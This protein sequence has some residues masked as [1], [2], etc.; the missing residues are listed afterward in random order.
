[1]NE[2]TYILVNLKTGKKIEHFEDEFFLLEDF[3]KRKISQGKDK[4]YS[5]EHWVGHSLF[6]IVELKDYFNEKK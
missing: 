5:I 3:C 4:N 6:E 2:H 1:M